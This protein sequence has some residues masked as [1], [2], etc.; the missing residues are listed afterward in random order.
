MSWNARRLVVCVVAVAALG[1]SGA[2]A[3]EPALENPGFEADGAGTA[4]PAGWKSRGAEAADFTEAGGRSGAFRLTHWSAEAYAVETAQT[5]DRLRDGWYTLR[6]WV[7]AKHRRQQQLRRRSIAGATA[8]AS[9]CR[10]RGPTSGS[11]SSF[12]RDVSHGSCTI[13]LHTDGGAASG[14]TSTTSSSSAVPRGSP[15]W[16]RTSRA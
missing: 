13:I 14:R 7:Q 8:S 9:T 15:S 11:R 2:G 16:A 3:Q 4:L 10:W 1:A 6:A 5:A 12:R